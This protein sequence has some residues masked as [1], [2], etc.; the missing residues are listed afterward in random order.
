MENFA[1]GG[2]RLRAAIRARLSM[3][4]RRPGEK[5]SDTMSVGRIDATLAQGAPAVKP[6]ASAVP[7]PSRMLDG[8][9]SD[10]GKAG[11]ARYPMDFTQM[12]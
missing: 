1:D 11:S 6:A 3:C 7:C 10:A 12:P 5:R 9:Q 4:R 8:D 2:E